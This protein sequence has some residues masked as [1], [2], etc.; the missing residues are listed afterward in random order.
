MIGGS[1]LSAPLSSPS[2]RAG[3]IRKRDY[4]RFR[5]RETSRKSIRLG[6]SGNKWLLE[7]NYRC[8]KM[9]NAARK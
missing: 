2:E 3:L 9:T 8:Q 5:P 7:K 1:L 4:A 6:L